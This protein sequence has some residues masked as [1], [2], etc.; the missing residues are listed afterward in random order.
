[1]TD[2]PCCGGGKCEASSKDFWDWFGTDKTFTVDQVKDL[3]KRI[4]T[5]NCGAIDAY[6]NKHVDKVFAEWCQELNG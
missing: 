4:E 6:L 3:L 2:G 1:M 5:F